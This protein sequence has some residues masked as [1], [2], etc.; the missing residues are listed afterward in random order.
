M[1]TAIAK[2]ISCQFLR[3]SLGRAASPLVIDVRRA[4]A[5]DADSV[6]V[7]GAIWRDPFAVGDWLK[8]LPRQRNIIVYC[9]HGHE[10]SKNVCAD[11]RAA[12]LD[13][14][15]LEG[16]IEA[17]QAEHGP[18]I[19]K[20]A[21]FSVPSLVNAPSKWI[22]RERPKIDRIACPWLI[23]RFIDPL[24]E[25]IFVPSAQVLSEARRLAATPYDI[26]GAVISH[27]ADQCSFDALID[28]FGINDPALHEL[29]V[30]VRAADTDS[31]ALA[32]Q[33]AGLLAVSLGLSALYDDDHDMLEHGMLVYDAL[34]AWLRS[35][36]G[37][38]HNAALFSS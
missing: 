11:L 10:I 37:E 20:R 16:G 24:A 36:R 30:I 32:P 8:F 1:D 9:V 7:A 15:F 17:W 29:A 34:Y 26:P 38:A 14:F 13:A 6:V 25:F 4:Q 23:R 27:R 33:A 5:F 22:T 28:D 31:L 19:R 12:G 3:A 18:T 2:S 21:E 35:A